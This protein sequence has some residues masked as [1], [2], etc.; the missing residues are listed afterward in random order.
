MAQL[1]SLAMREKGAF[2]AATNHYILPA[3]VVGF[4]K[5]NL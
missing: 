1:N 4:A 2:V 3:K 5:G